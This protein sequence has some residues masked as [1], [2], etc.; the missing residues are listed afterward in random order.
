MKI[1]QMSSP[2]PKNTKGKEKPPKPWSLL[3]ALQDRPKI[4]KGAARVVK[5]VCQSTQG[6]SKVVFRLL[7]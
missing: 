2:Q 4:I 5:P 3:D 1:P 6:C 7:A